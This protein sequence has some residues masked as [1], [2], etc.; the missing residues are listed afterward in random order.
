M[1][2][3]LLTIDRPQTDQFDTL[4]NDVSLERILISFAIPVI[5]SR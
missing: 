2:S 5:L 1:E 3:D 4:F